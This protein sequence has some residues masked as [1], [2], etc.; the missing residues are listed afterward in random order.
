[1]GQ[2]HKFSLV[3]LGYHCIMHLGKSIKP[4]VC[5]DLDGMRFFLAPCSWLLFGSLLLSSLFL[6]SCCRSRL[7]SCYVSLSS[8]YRRIW[9]WGAFLARRALSSTRG[10]Y[11]ISLIALEASW[12]C[13][14]SAKLFLLQRSATWRQKLIITKVESKTFTDLYIYVTALGQ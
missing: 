13:S 11:F 12:N 7:L 8:R 14:G 4:K 1:M 9:V 6:D 5:E 10:W 2:T 3:S